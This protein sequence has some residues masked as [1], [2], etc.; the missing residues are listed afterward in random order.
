MGNCDPIGGVAGLVRTLGLEAAA[1]ES[2]LGLFHSSAVNRTSLQMALFSWI[3]LRFR[4]LIVRI[5]DKE[6]LVLDA[7]KQAKSGKRMPGVKWHHQESSSASKKEYVTAHSF[8][9]MGL[10]VNCLGCVSCLVFLIRM[11]D[12]FRVNNRD[13]LSLKEKVGELISAN[14]TILAGRIVVCDAWY[15]AQQVLKP[16][17]QASVTVITRVGKD[18]VACFD[19]VRIPG[20]RGRPPKYGKT[21][22]LLSLFDTL[23]MFTGK[24]K[25][26]AGEA[27]QV[28]YWHIELLWQPIK[29]K[30]LFVGTQ[31]ENGR[32]IILLCTDLGIDPLEVIQGYVYRSSI[33]HSFW[34]STQFFSSWTYRFWT[35]LPLVKSDLKGNFNL[36]LCND[37]L[38]EVFKGKIRAYEIFLTIGFLSHA[39]FLFVG[40]QLESSSINTNIL[41][42]RSKNR[43]TGASIPIMRALLVADY[44]NIV[45]SRKSDTEP[46]KFVIERHNNCALNHVPEKAA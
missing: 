39:V 44:Q 6:L 36:H 5:G 14:A 41:F 38:R 9:C 11:I 29:Q 1:Y 10:V 19:P 16:S 8:E 26:C 40:M 31:D 2:M 27:R 28:T 30:V 24:V 21:I 13:G 7:K 25:S 20:V 46:G 33:E 34:L 17:I 35:K 4:N 15:A 45:R 42:F 37:H 22:K 18:A 32:R 12:G 43:V 23:E 3:R